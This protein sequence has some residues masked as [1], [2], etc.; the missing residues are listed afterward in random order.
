VVREQGERIEALNRKVDGMA[1][2]VEEVQAA[3]A[4]LKADLE[5]KAAEAKAEF[6]KLE[7]EVAEGKPTDLTGLKESVEGIDAAVKGAVVPTD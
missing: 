1:V 3:L 2:T 5:A 7:K 6:E 4:A